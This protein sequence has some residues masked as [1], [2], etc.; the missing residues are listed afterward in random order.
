MSRDATV[1]YAEG[2]DALSASPLVS[3]RFL[4]DFGRLPTN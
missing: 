2:A 3:M 1:R 4:S